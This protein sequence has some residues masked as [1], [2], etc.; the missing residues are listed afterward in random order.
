M[1][2]EYKLS[3]YRKDLL[4]PSKEFPWKWGWRPK[5]GGLT[6]REAKELNLSEAEAYRLG[7]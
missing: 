2:K 4:T 1:W 5:Y 7:Q 6:M 3:T